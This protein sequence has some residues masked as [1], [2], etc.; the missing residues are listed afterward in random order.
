MWDA[1]DSVAPAAPPLELGPDPDEPDQIVTVPEDALE[2]GCYIEGQ[3]TFEQTALLQSLCV[4][5]AEGGRGF[6][7]M[8]PQCGPPLDFL[9]RLPADRLDDVVWI[10][11]DRT[12]LP[13]ELEIPWLKRV[14]I[15]LF[16]VPELDHEAFTHDPVD[17]RVNAYLDALSTA[18][19]DFD[20]NVARALSWMLPA[21]IRRAD[22]TPYSPRSSLALP[23]LRAVRDAQTLSPDAHEDLAIAFNAIKGVQDREGRPVR[24]ASQLLGRVHDPTPTNPLLYETTY[25]IGRALAEDPIVLVGGNLDSPN[26]DVALRTQLVVAA[27]ACRLWEAA[28][29]AD[30][31]ATP[32]PLVVDGV[33]ELVA[34]DGTVFQRLV[35]EGDTLPVAPL[36]SG[37]PTAALAEPL[38]AAIA[39][40]LDTRIVVTDRTPTAANAA[41]QAD[42]IG[43]ALRTA[44]LDTVERYLEQEASGTVAE[45]PLCWLRTDA[46]GMLAG[47]SDVPRAV[48]PAVVPA[49]P[50]PRHGPAAVATALRQSLHCHGTIADHVPADRRDQRRAELRDHDR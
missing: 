40:E 36:M 49:M 4:Q 30:G 46:S 24:D 22:C 21:F 17:L 42:D 38:S 44:S 33:D 32:V 23:A 48:Q 5:L 9:A 39:T 18:T 13:S 29:I 43:A 45:G 37:P 34:G 41:G 26:A 27:L 28:T 35:A 19:T 12:Q 3:Q 47:S 16:D 25:D 8:A 20:W 2:Q 14:T 50:D 15:D 7:Y 6:C 31:S 1:D 11:V 10:D